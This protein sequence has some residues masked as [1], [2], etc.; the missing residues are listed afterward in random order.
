MLAVVPS[1][2]KKLLT[3]IEILMILSSNE[4]KVPVPTSSI[5]SPLHPHY[6]IAFFNVIEQACQWQPLWR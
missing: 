5:T 3:T 4:T 1:A 2:E 6:R